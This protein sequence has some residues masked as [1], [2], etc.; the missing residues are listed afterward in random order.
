MTGPGQAVE[1]SAPTG[2]RAAG[3]VPLAVFYGLY[4]AATG[5]TLPFLPAY[6][7]SLNFSGSE[8]GVLLALQPTFTLVVPPVWGWLA[9]RFGRADLVL[10]ALAVGAA[11]GFAPLL[12]AEHFLTAAAAMAAYAFFASSITTVIDS[13]ALQRVA[14]HGGAFS[15]IRL[16][17]SVGFVLSSTLVG[18]SIAR[19]DST[20]V[21]V[22]LALMVSY[23]LWSR[24]VRAR[25]VPVPPRHPF[26]GLALLRHRD[27]ALMLIASALHWI[28]SAPYHGIFSIHV[29]AIGLDPWVVGICAGLGVLAEI[30]V[31]FAYPRFADRIAPR[32]VLFV[33]FAASA[34]RWLGISLVDDA[35][36]LIALSLLHGLSFGS[37]YV[38]AVAFVARRVPDSLRASGQALMVSITFGVGGVVGYLGAGTGYQ[39]LGGFTLFAVA[40]ALELVPAVLILLVRGPSMTRAALEPLAKGHPAQ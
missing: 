10:S 35:A 28:A 9:D 21:V 5:I 14:L 20:V 1:S 16:F 34:I 17:G 4:F 29:T 38:A 7:E 25:A 27:L 36:S 30:G 37:F 31:M 26:A 18:V 23:A 11:L 22:A 33:S 3:A 8:I 2:V 39:L 12:F 24:T 13:L 15:R 6:F 19:I 40:A 32:H